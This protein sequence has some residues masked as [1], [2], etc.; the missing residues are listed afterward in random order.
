[1]SPELTIKARSL[2]RGIL[3]AELHAGQLL[4]SPALSSLAV[5]FLPHALHVKLIILLLTSNVHR[6]YRL[7]P[8]VARRRRCVRPSIISRAN[9]DSRAYFAAVQAGIE[10]LIC[11]RD[12][13]DED[14]AWHYAIANQRDRRNLSDAELLSLVTAVDK[15]K[16]R[17]GDR[18]SKDAKSKIS[19]ETIDPGP[20]RNETAAV[21]GIS[22]RQVKKVRAISSYAA[23]RQRI[24]NLF[25]TAHR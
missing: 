6:S 3:T 1:M 18:K 5:N 10:V 23:N 8:I 15:R 13:P 21:A 2:S 7:Y 12:F 22:P 25:P 24:A 20:S 16:L 9:G 11:F 17:G 19:G 4:V 14:A